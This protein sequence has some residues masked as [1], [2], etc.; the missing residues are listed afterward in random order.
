MRCG[1]RR[2]FHL[3]RGL[4]ESL[5]KQRR[6]RSLALQA[7]KAG[8]YVQQIAVGVST[9]AVGWVMQHTL[10]LLLLLS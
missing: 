7:V 2:D 8:L 4:H 3:R 6:M 9:V 10:D 5:H 1:I